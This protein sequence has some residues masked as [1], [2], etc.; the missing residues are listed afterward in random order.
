M[1]QEQALV[2]EM[3][4]LRKFALRLTRNDSDADDLTQATLLRALEKK[5]YFQDGSNLFRWTSKI[6]FNIFA[7]EYRHKKKFDTQYDPEPHIERAAIS[8]PQE[9]ATD[10][11]TVTRKMDD[12]SPDRR[13]II[14]MVCFRGL[15]YEEVSEMLEIPVGTVRSRLFRARKDLTEML[16]D[17]P[18]L[19]AAAAAA[20]LLLHHQQMRMNA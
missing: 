11:A 17:R 20:N 15:G 2:K 3:G 4:N 18:H 8:P 16:E 1:F 12:L 14:N 13:Q 6:M 10:L 7:S 19:P 9:A 5:D